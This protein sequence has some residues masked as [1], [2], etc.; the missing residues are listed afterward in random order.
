MFE[1]V[2]PKV[3]RTWSA[4]IRRIDGRSLLVLGPIGWHPPGFWE[5]YWDR[6]W[7]GAGEEFDRAVAAMIAEEELAPPAK[8]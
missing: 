7:E 3:S 2:S 4:S 1:I 6:R 5:E 8:P